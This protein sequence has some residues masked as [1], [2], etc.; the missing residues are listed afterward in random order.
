MSDKEAEEIFDKELQ[1]V[2]LKDGINANTS[3][4][5]TVSAN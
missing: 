3:A 5:S 4:E 1:N 2:N